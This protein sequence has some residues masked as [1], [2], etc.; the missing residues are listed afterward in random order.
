[1]LLGSKGPAV[2]QGPLI[3][4][5]EVRMIEIKFKMSLHTAN[6]FSPNAGPVLFWGN[7]ASPLLVMVIGQFLK[8]YGLT[9]LVF[10]K[11]ISGFI[12]EAQPPEILL[13]RGLKV[14]GVSK[15]LYMS[16]KKS[17]FH[18]N[19]VILY[20]PAT[21]ANP[22]VA[23]RISRYIFTKEEEEI[24]RSLRKLAYDIKEAYYAHRNK[25][26]DAIQ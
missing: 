6:P 11:G 18:Q 24:E 20:Y 21:K 23:V 8:E 3:F 2:D 14:G 26:S 25:I 5:L 17:V 9:T 10:S 1:M 12:M 22:I 15:G 13:V 7:K 16:I 4:S 19:K